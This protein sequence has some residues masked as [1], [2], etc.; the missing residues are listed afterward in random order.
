MMTSTSGRPPSTNGLVKNTLY[1]VIT[2][3]LLI[4][5]ALGTIPV[6]VKGLA[7]ERFG[8]LSLI[9]ILVGYFS[10]LDLGISR[11]NAKFLAEALAISDGRTVHLVVWN[12]LALGLGIGLGSG[13]LL[14]AVSPYIVHHV[15]N[16]SGPLGE[17][18]TRAFIWSA[19]GLPFV[20]E[21][22]VIRG[23]QTAHQR[24]GL[25]N[26]FQGSVGVMQWLGVALMVSMGEGF[27]AVIFLT[28]GVR[29]LT[30]IA[31]FLTLPR[32]VPGLFGEVAWD[33]TVI[34]KLLGYGGWVTVSQLVGPL[35]L[36]LDRVFIGALL[37][38]A[39]VTYYT[40]PQ[41]AIS[42]LL[43]VPISLTATLFPVM[44]GHS[45]V[46]GMSDISNFLYARAVKYLLLVMLPLSLMLIAFAPWILAA[47]MGG[48]FAAHSTAVFQIIAGGILF[49][50]L[51]Q[52]P[53]TA[54]QAYSRPDLAAKL[55]VVELP[56]MIGLN[57]LLLPWIGVVGAA[58]AW[59]VRVAVDAILLFVLARRSVGLSAR[60]ARAP[61]G[62][63]SIAAHMAFA[64]G[65][66]CAALLF[67]ELAV[68]TLFVT[69]SVLAYA[70]FTWKV[71][72]DDADR[73]FFLGMRA[74]VFGAT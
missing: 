23:I 26:I 4:I 10:L 2:Q 34:R 61:L 73:H 67:D 43:I 46:S 69:A 72:F 5:L 53:A 41:E 55:H 32:L 33:R 58:I 3:G 30:T 35:Y 31:A 13:L 70:L 28:V 21:F 38:L 6:I 50:A 20:V 52:I 64:V 16:L 17:Q 57:F 15:L 47:W 62:S 7:P 36:Y 27:D 60:S 25:I 63:W 22:G 12:S 54:L 18:A 9:W 48:E 24:F 45:A 14:S 49:N 44:S 39:A 68:R 65:S 51:A 42:R 66:V 19:I 40:V 8:L 11:A 29:V 37:S 56:L 74:R 71:F 1:N 59:S